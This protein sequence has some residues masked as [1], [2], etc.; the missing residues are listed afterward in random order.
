MKLKAKGQFQLTGAAAAALACVSTHLTAATTESPTNSVAVPLEAIPGGAA[1]VLQQSAANPEQNWNWHVQNT[2]IAQGYPAFS[3]PYSGPNSLP[4]GGEV[5][6]TVSFDL[7]GGV[8]LWS[9]AEAHVDGMMWQGFGFNDTL[10]AEGFPNG[11]GFRL[12]TA[13]PNGSISRLFIRQTIGLGGDQEDVPDD[14]LTLAGKQDVSRLTF[15]VGRFSPKDIFDNNAYA[16]DPRTQ[17]MNWGLMANEAWDYPADAIGFTTGLAVELNQPKWTLRYG[18]FQ[19]PRYQNNLTAEDRYL[20]WPFD[21]SA[22]D[23]PF[24]DSWGMVTEFER[25]YTIGDHPGTIRFLAFLNRANMADY[26]A[27]T[28]IL[29]ADGPEA[30]WEAARTYHFKYGFGLNWQQEIVKNVG[31]FSRLGWNDDQEEGWVF[32]DVG[33]AASVGLSVKG[34]AWHRPGDTFGLAAVASGASVAERDFLAAGGTGILAGDG[35]LNYGLEKILETYYDFNVWK[36]VH[37][38]VDYQFIANPAFNQDRGPV[39]VFGARV[40]WEF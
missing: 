16:N 19:M 8:R 35:A 7:M 30:D 12:G 2:D 20:K 6:E 5:R 3:A 33:Y 9:G 10:G 40:H 29:L 26:R 21:G 37:L 34:Q 32:S 24:L 36:T 38:A 31:V 14:Q 17:F 18:F 1:P 15:T 23:G 22:Q 4:G 27:A 11:E 13:V 25:R 28:A 39:S